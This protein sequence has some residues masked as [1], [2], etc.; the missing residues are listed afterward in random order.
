[1][2][3][4]QEFELSSKYHLWSFALHFPT[5]GSKWQTIREVL[6]ITICITIIGLKCSYHYQKL[7]HHPLEGLSNNKEPQLKTL[8]KL[9]ISFLRTDNKQVLETNIQRK[10]FIRKTNSREVY[11]FAQTTHQ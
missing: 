6:F 3:L 11:L 5:L 7:L 2:K 1:M 10:L 9:I 4:I 8:R